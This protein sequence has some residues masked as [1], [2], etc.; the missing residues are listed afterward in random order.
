MILDTCRSTRNARAVECGIRLLKRHR[1][2][3]T[4]FDKLPVGCEVTSQIAAIN[5]MV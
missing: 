5:Q 2:V 3:S 1:A 4:R